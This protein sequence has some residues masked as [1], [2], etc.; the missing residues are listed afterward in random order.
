[1]TKYLLGRII[2]GVFSVVIVV[3]IVMLLVYSFMD[4][5][6]IF[7]TDP[8]FSKK[9]SNAVTIYKM[10]RW[11][12]YGYL[13]YIP[14]ED[15]VNELKQNGE[16]DEETRVA[17]ITIGSKK[18]GSSDS[19]VVKEYVNKF[20]AKYE[21]MGYTVDR[22]PGDTKPGSSKYKDGGQPQLYAY[23]DIPVLTRLWDYFAGLITIDNIHYAQG[24]EDSERGLS[25]TFFDPVYG[26]EKFSPAIM[27][28]GTKHKYLLYC[29][30]S[31]PFI[32][33]N[34]ISVNLGKSYTVNKGIDVFNTMNDSQGSLSF[35]LVHYPSGLVVE[36]A[37]NLHSATYMAG[38]SQKE[39]YS[40]YFTDDYTN[41]IT[42]KDGL[43]RM[44]YSFTIGLISVILSYLLGI[45]LGT[46]MALKKDKFVDKIGTFYIVFIIAVP[47]LAYIFLFK[48]IGQ[49][50]FGLPGT[51]DLQLNT[52]TIYILPIISLA[53]PSVAGFMKWIR[54]YMIDQMNSDYVK[55]ARS[56]G[57]SEGE[58]FSKHILKNAIIPIVHGIPGSFLGALVGA[59]IT[60][61]VYVVPGTGNLLTKAINAYDNGV[62]VGVTL[63][64][65]VLSV[66]SIILG[67]ILMSLIDPRISFSSKNER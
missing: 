13:D 18:D 55:F 58:I 29:S 50:L 20:K 2:R 5:E 8:V 64:Y 42:N 48:S 46:V 3:I 4:R 44:G 39:L 19:D 7:R 15:Y 30:D 56:G 60:E 62:I 12:D 65:A 9:K 40:Q 66:V 11:E 24:I 31:F 37:D 38:S 10:Q 67:D 34:L 49:K 17:I 51:F 33:Q 27:G 54:R 16:I 43:S 57:L 41:T 36:S 26:G 14:Y 35:R 52:W 61:S 63:F 23:K 21:A 6:L 45:P 32:H 28:N 1:M 53:L 47:S 59:I 22:M 25:F